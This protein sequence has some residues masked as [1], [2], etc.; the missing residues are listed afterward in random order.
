M[1]M[2]LPPPPPTRRLPTTSVVQERRTGDGNCGDSS[3]IKALHEYQQAHGLCF[4][5]SKRWGQEHTCPTSVLLHVVKE[6]LELFSLDGSDD[7]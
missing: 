5:C 4:K 1:P 7:S 2:T 6:L 3:K